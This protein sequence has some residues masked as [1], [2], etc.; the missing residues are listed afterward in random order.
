LMVK[1]VTGHRKPINDIVAL[2]A[3]WEEGGGQ[4]NTH[5]A[6]LSAITGKAFKIQNIRANRTPPA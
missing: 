6:R 5:S 1:E 4:I 2:T 3:A